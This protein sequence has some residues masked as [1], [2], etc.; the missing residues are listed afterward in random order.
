MLIVHDPKAGH[1]GHFYL[2]YEPVFDNF[3]FQKFKTFEEAEEFALAN[4]IKVKGYVSLGAS[5]KMM[6]K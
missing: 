1:R 4:S 5:E 2:A 3:S 6:E